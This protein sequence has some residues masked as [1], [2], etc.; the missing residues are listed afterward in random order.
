MGNSQAA[1]EALP[2]L[3]PP[4]SGHQVSAEGDHLAAPAIV[5]D[6]KSVFP[7]AFLM[8][9]TIAACLSSREPLGPVY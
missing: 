2:P 3:P 7:F 6:L 4:A 9:A 1:L 5:L 8:S